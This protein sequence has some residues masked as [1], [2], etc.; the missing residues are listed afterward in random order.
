MEFQ[1]DFIFEMW[2]PIIVEAKNEEEALQKAWALWDKMPAEGD[3]ID[4]SSSAFINKD[5]KEK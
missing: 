1:V 5:F 2:K 3:Y 4:D